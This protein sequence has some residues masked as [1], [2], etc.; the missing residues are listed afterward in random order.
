MGLT[1][2]TF[3]DHRLK[4]IAEKVT[5]NTNELQQFIQNLIASLHESNGIGLAATQVGS[6]L[7]LF[8]L[9]LSEEQNAPR[10]FI[11]PVIIDSDGV[12]TSEEGCLSFP[13]VYASIQRWKK[14]TVEY[15]DQNFN[16]QTISCDDLLAI[17][18]QHELDH[19]NGITLYDKL[20]KLKQ[21]RIKTKLFKQNALAK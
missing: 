11:N 9:D 13:N 7:R 16:P 3:P 12:V 8:V 6:K 15:L 2:L 17:C 14:I 5:E 1:I 18:I 4:Q 10:C 21:E 19:L 20:S